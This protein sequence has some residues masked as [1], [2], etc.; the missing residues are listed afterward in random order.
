MTGAIAERDWLRVPLLAVCAALVGGFISI[1]PY[2]AVGVVVLGLV[3]VLAFRA[4][5]LHLTILLALT[6][7]VPFS[8]QNALSGGGGAGVFPSDLFLLTGLVR[9]VVVALQRP[10]DRRR[11][12]PAALMVLFLV[13]V[14]LQLLHGRAA[15]ADVSQAGGEARA[16]LG[17]GTLLIALPVLE[18][19]RARSQLVRGLLAVGLALG[20]WGIAQWTLG[21]Q[22][23]GAGDVGVREGVNYTT[24]GRGQ[25]Q[26][27]L[28]GFPVAIVMA[29]A[30]LMSGQRLSLAG[31]TALL[32]VVLLNG[33]SLLLTYERTFWVATA[34]GLA[35][36]II[37]TEGLQR[38]KAA[39]WT[40]TVAGIAFAALST[41]NP[42]VLTA[43]R[44]RF[45]SLGQYANDDSLRYRIV[46]SQHVVAQVDA[47]PIIG[48]GLAAQIFWGRPWENVPERA[49]YYNHN[50]FLAV[51]W[52][53]G[54]PLAILLLG[55]VAWC[56][57]APARR[58]RDPPARALTLGAQAGLLS[59][60]VASVTFPSFTTLAITAAMGVL[61]AICVSTGDGD[62]ETCSMPTG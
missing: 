30:V 37:K 11:L 22:F 42:S 55:L 3:L 49:Y 16:L 51:A 40:V 5:A 9:G 35:V 41:W 57:V 13:G 20:L 6:V 33:V 17:F 32:A 38:L 7:V 58:D 28:Y 44:E 36:V 23:G 60:A 26:G 45:L 27:G 53:L 34:V 1:A 8:V 24:A 19:P 56:V 10:I 4:P 43:A 52:K 62:G 29:S 54:L 18:D 39:A 15:G 47:R 48:S 31:R 12:V 14:L 59:L 61:M 46:E 50:G 21:I 25:V 2:A